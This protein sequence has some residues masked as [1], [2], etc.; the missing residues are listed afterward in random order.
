MS[1][2]VRQIR[3]PSPEH[4]CPAA[5]HLA[6]VLYFTRVRVLGSRHSVSFLMYLLVALTGSD[7][8][9]A[10]GVG[11]GRMFSAYSLAAP[12][13]SEVRPTR[14]THSPGRVQWY[15]EVHTAPGILITSTP[16]APPSANSNEARESR[17]SAHLILLF[18]QLGRE[19]PKPSISL[20][21]PV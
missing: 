11:F 13:R 18:E 10:L 4:R 15:L 7:W 21:G 9:A 3:A 1:V 6:Q 17:P 5:W 20:G 14:N 2:S 8:R 19:R 16:T 12:T